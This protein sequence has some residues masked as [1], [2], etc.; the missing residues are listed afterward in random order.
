[1]IAVARNHTPAKREIQWHVGTSEDMFFLE[2]E[3]FDW[4]VCQQG[5]QYFNDKDRALLEIYRVL[6][7]NGGLAMKM[8]CE[9]K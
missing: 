5:F 3:A 6:K 2:N 4:V 8:T 9:G 7:S 1:M